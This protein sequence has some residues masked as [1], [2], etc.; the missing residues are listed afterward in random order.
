[1]GENLREFRVSVPI[2]EGLLKR[3]S[4]FKQLD[5]TLVGVVHWVTANSRK[6]SPVKIYFQAVRESFLPRKETRCTVVGPRFLVGGFCPLPLTTFLNETLHDVHMFVDQTIELST[7]GIGICAME[8][9]CV[10]AGRA[11]N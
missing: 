2:R 6:F 1:M 7:R 3:K 8:G 11:D 5:T 9:Q 10:V 4:I